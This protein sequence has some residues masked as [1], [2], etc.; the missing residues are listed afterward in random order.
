MTEVK[1]KVRPLQIFIYSCPKKQQT[2]RLQ[3]CKN[4]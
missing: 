3:I 1:F 4:L 2:K